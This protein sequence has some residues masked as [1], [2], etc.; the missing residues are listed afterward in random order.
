MPNVLFTRR[1]CITAISVLASSSLPLYAQE[2]FRPATVQTSVPLT[3]RYEIVQSPLAAKWTFRLDKYCGQV[4]QLV[5][6]KDDD[7]AWES[8]PVVGLIKCLSDSRPRFQLFSSG[9]AARHTYLLNV[10]TGQSWVLSTVKD[11]KQ[12]EITGWFPF[13][14]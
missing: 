8:M 2:E 14:E 11:K 13:A 10:E 4:S 12:G 3:S 6:T 7:V 9:L 5:K 1:A